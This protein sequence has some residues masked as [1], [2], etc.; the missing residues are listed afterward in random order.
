MSNAN[1]LIIPIGRDKVESRE[2]L[3][4]GFRTKEQFETVRL[5]IIREDFDFSCGPKNLF[6]PFCESC[7]CGKRGK[8]QGPF[9]FMWYDK[10]G[11]LHGTRIGKSGKIL[12]EYKDGEIIN[13]AKV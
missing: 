8:Y 9:M 13:S 11:N 6:N 2:E 1:V 12:G 5:I 3:H 7:G 4:E 10:Q